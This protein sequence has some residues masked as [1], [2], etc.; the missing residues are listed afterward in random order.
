MPKAK[1]A[2]KALS[3][4]R[5]AAG[6]VHPVEHLPGCAAK[7]SDRK[8]VQRLPSLSGLEMR[9]PQHITHQCDGIESRWRLNSLCIGD[10]EGDSCIRHRSPSW[11]R[12]V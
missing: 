12:L 11:P 4:I 2:W 9:A 3:I 10:D 5:G 6:V 7:A 8:P 1:T